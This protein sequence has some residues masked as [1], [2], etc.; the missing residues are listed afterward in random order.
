V[1]QP[2]RSVGVDFAPPLPAERRYLRIGA[3]AIAVLLIGGLVVGVTQ[4]LLR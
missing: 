3:A 2:D 4:L 1:S